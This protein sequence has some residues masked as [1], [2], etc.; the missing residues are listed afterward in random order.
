MS[1]VFGHGQLRLYLLSLLEEG[2]RHGYE[3]IRA[4]EERFDGLYTPSA[5]TVYPRLQRLE[6]EGLI[7]RESSGADAGRKVVY[8]ITDAGRA[9]V[10]SRRDDL[11]AL[12]LDLAASVSR[13]A[14][15]V[16]R[17]VRTGSKDLRG[18]LAEAAKVARAS[19]RAVPAP[20]GAA[21]EHV[22]PS[23]AR[24]NG[25]GPAVGPGLEQAL[26]DLRDEVSRSLSAVDSAQLAERARAVV[27]AATGEVRK[28][29]GG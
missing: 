22:S 16:R 17:R 14:E 28:L 15:D 12:D 2:P 23:D 26:R 13:L 9:E 6:E 1:S 19:S 4:L 8:R 3:V 7:V 18:E 10:G 27:E 21:G 5:G 29:R 20:E 11:A 25:Y 24:A